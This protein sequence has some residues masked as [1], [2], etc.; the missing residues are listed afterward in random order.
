MASLTARRKSSIPGAGFGMVG[1]VITLAIV[2]LGF[3]IGGTVF[4][5]DSGS[6]NSD[7]GSNSTSPVNRA[8]DVVGESTLETAESAVQTVAT[9]AGFGAMSA[10]SLGFDEPSIH[11]VSG[12]TSSDTTV[13]V[14]G[15]G[16]QSAV[17]GATP[18]TS[19]Q[20]IL[21]SAGSA[22]ASG[23]IGS[24]GGSVMLAT[25]SDN[26]SGTGSCL[27]V[28]MT[29]GATWFGAESDQTSC[30]ATS[31]AAAPQ[32]S[33]VTSTSIGWSPTTFPTP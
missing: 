10:Q 33:A 13:S 7:L 4:F 15:S 29:T 2:A 6:S 26:L 21:G 32:P 3:A 24:S 25:Y 23:G 1:L 20:S 9:T 27:F 17:P 30:A 14:A 19:L 28:W 5:G 22:G 12:P 16:A 8:Y 11:F 18:T 31:L